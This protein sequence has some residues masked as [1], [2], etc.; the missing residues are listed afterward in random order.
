MIGHIAF[1]PVL[2]NGEITNWYGLAPVSVLSEQQG[3]GI[4]KALI[5]QGLARATA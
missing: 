2:I 3:K 4:G 1:S 5:N